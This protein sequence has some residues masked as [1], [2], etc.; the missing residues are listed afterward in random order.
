[1]SCYS[2]AI[3]TMYYYAVSIEM[4]FLYLFYFIIYIAPHAQV[5]LN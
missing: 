2:T 5:D 4:Y 1:M 3:L